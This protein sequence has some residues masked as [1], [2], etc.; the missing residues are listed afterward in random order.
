MSFPSPVKISPVK[1]SRNI[2]QTWSTK[3]ISNEFKSLTETW[4]QF[5][6]N[7]AYFLYDDDDC[8][9]FI[10]KHF[11]DRVYNAYCRIIP[12]AFKADLWRYCILYIYGG[13]YCDIDTICMHS[14]DAF[15]NEDIEFMTAID[16]NPPSPL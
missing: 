14:L 12:G 13:V 6:P 4:T 5:N 11:D 3:N 8:H 9:A 10:K 7:Y 16:L 15:L 1:I 2:F